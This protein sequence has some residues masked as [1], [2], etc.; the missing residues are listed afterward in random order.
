MGNDRISCQIGEF[1]FIMKAIEMISKIFKG[2]KKDED[3]LEGGKH[4]IKTSIQD[5]ELQ[6]KKIFEA[7]KDNPAE[8][9]KN[10]DRYVRIKKDVNTKKG[11]ELGIP[12]EIIKQ[13]NYNM[14]YAAKDERSTLARDLEGMKR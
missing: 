5:L 2:T 13:M 1:E 9:L 14:D 7:C 11:E 4:L 6:R 12:K 8:A 3:W 10:F